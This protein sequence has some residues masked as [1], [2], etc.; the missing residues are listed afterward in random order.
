MDSMRKYI[1]ISLLFIV[2]IFSFSGIVHAQQDG[3]IVQ[4]KQVIVKA[5]VLEIVKQEVVDIPGT[6]TQH[7][8]QSIKVKIIEGDEK[9]KVLT[10]DNDYL[11]LKVGEVF[12]LMHTTGALDGSDYYSVDEPYRIPQVLTI[13]GLFILAVFL[14]GGLQGIRGI[15]SLAGSFLLIFYVLLPGILHGY[16]P[17]LVTIGVSSLIIIVGSYITH[18]INKTTSSAI[19]GMIATVSFTGAFAYWAV[20]FTR[21]SG[22]ATEEVSY[23]NFDTHG[24]VSIIGLL[25]G[26]IMIGLLGVLYDIAISQAISVE[27]CSSCAKENYI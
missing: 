4:D 17:L 23:L 18:G 2:S 10:V 16:N 21:L 27:N 8:N 14:F 7:S 9:D 5:Q 22:F 19:L 26:G 1:F 20:Y 15:I 24:G 25:L 3:Q 13:V 6:D 12:Y 11:N